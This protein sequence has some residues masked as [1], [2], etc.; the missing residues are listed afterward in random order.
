[1]YLRMKAA[2]LCVFTTILLY[3]RSQSVRYVP[4]S[5]HPS[6]L[7]F[8]LFCTKRY[9][10][11]PVHMIFKSINFVRGAAMLP[12]MVRGKLNGEMA[13]TNYININTDSQESIYYL[14]LPPD[15]LSGH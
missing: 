3:D 15:Y 4:Y 1:M 2:V 13:Y 11:R 10:P 14:N 9:Q 6:I 7:H 5:A 8:P 12:S